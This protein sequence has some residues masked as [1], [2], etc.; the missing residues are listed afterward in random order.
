MS[1]TQCFS[2][3][4]GTALV[5]ITVHL[6]ARGTMVPVG[7]VPLVVAVTTADPAGTMGAAVTTECLT[8][9]L[10]SVHSHWKLEHINTEC[11][12]CAQ[13]STLEVI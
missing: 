8:G 5:Q 9:R 7:T 6:P 1:K 10:L 3:F 13:I 11:V 4:P 12:M 2:A